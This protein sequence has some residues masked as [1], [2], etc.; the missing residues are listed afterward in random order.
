ME[1]EP[2]KVTTSELR[3]A[4]ERVLRYLE[5][6]DRATFSIEEDFYWS[7]PPS[8]AYDN[9][10]QPAE[11]TVGQLTDDWAHVKALVEGREEPLGYALVWISSVLRRVGEKSAG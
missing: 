1:A 7:V 8:A 3:T 5:E 11:L 9:Y 2:M 10:S 4:L 6:T